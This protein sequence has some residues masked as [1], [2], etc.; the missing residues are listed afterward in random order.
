MLPTKAGIA[1]HSIHYYTIGGTPFPEKYS[2][3]FEYALQV[4]EWQGVRTTTIIVSGSPKPKI[5]P[6]SR[7][8]SFLAE[9]HRP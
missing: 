8:F 7:G 9:F 1:T 5:G 3:I 4:T 6:T 2:N